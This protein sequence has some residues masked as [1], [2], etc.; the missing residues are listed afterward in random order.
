M[1]RSFNVNLY[2]CRTCYIKCQ[3]G[4]VPC[5]AVSN[6][7]EVFDLPVE[8]QSI[9]LL[10]KVLIAKR[11]LF[12]KVTIMPSG[13]MLKIFGTI[14]NVPVDTVEVTDLLPCS[15]DS[16]GLVY[17]K[18]KRKLEYYGHVLLEPVRPMFLER[19]L[20]LLK[21]NNPLYFNIVAKTENI[22][23]HLS[24]LNVFDNS[25][26]QNINDGFVVNNVVDVQELLKDVNVDILIFID[27]KEETIEEATSYS[28]E[29]SS[30]ANETCLVSLNA[31]SS[32]DN[33]CINIAPGEGKQLKSILNDKFCEELAFPYLFPASK[34]CY[35]EL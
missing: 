15:A 24:L 14:C 34:F 30:I 35:I 29:Y 21:E 11:L 9:R 27:D 5:Q 16:N 8:F 10:E 25:C 7:L 2:I 23:P 20:K 19:L 31:Q 3:K 33:D 4:K 28:D 17:V 6:K 32:V 1:G 13:Q 18:L 12:K 22:H 26:K